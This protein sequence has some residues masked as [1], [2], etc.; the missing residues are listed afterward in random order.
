MRKT[1]Y[2][3]LADYLRRGP[4]TQAQLAARIGMSQPSISGA[5]YGHGSYRKFKLISDA[6]GVPLASFARKDV[7]A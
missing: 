5:K 2:T 3:S 1:H 4:E 7:A 6:T